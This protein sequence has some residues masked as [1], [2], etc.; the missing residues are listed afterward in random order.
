MDQRSILYG[1][2]FANVPSVNSLSSIVSFC[3]RPIVQ[4]ELNRISIAV[5]N[6]VF[7]VV[8]QSYFSTFRDMMYGDK[9][10]AVC[11]VGHAHAGYGKMKLDTT[12]QFDDLKSIIALQSNQY[13][14]VEPF[15][16][17]AFDIRIQKIGDKISAHKRVTVSGNW[18]TNT[19][20]SLTEDIPM[21]PIYTRWVE[22]AQKMFGGL[23]ILSIDAIHNKDTGE[24]VIMEVNGTASGFRSEEN[25]IDLR[26]LVV[27]RMN[28]LKM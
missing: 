15:I 9:F 23:D 13:C 16:N 22:E 5:G 12:P 4:A 21:T 7:P 14:T 10:P 2:L 28:A 25:N 26:D 6:D 27:D 8:G 24:E 3:D 11:K 19:G 17:G 18:K 20:S 1:L